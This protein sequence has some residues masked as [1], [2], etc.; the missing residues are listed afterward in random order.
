[1]LTL[2]IVLLLAASPPAPHLELTAKSA[3]S[4]DAPRDF[5]VEPVL[6]VDPRDAQRLVA[7]A[8]V[9]GERSGTAVYRSTTGGASW[10]RATFGEKNE[11]VFPGIDPALAFSADGRAYIATITPWRVFASADGGLSFS[12]PALVP[13]TSADRDFLAA[14][15]PGPNAASRVFAV[16]KIPIRVF[17][18]LA[19]DI[20]AFAQSTDLGASFEAPHLFL[21]PP[22]SQVLHAPSDLLALPSGELLVAYETFALPLSNPPALIGK[23]YTF[24]LRPWGAASEPRPAAEYRKIGHPEEWVSSLGLGGGRL[25]LGPGQGTEPGRLHLAYLDYRNDKYR[26]FVRSSA[27]LGATWEEPVELETDA[28]GNHSTPAVAVDGAGNLAVAWNDRRQDLSDRCFR[29]R[30]TLS[31][32][33]GRSF[34]PSLAVGEASCP[35][36]DQPRSGEFNPANPRHR[37]GNGGETLG[38]VA[39]SVGRFGVVFPEGRAENLGLSWAEVALRVP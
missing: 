6:A 2:A 35:N 28:P 7:A 19:E 24:R 29:T 1:M 31:R 17:G 34:L 22:E 10:R 5:F 33:G 3:I 21:P 20:L 27:D 13:S 39:L 15:G 18:S 26:V 4:A 12:A 30:L 9:F 36:G 32:D 23:L 16:A 8:M 11:A 38:L 25:A 37:F 14:V